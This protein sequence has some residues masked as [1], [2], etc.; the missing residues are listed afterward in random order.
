MLTKQRGLIY[1]TWTQK[2]NLFAAILNKVYTNSVY[3][4]LYLRKEGEGKNISC[5]HIYVKHIE[6][7]CLML[8]SKMEV[9]SARNHCPRKAS[10][11][12]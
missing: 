4:G 12:I 3:P 5:I 9:N 8:L 1:L 10:T 6:V 2:N 7:S 11:V